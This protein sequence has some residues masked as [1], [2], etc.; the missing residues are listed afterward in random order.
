M[1]IS[2]SLSGNSLYIKRNYV[3][4]FFPPLYSLLYEVF[5]KKTVQ[6]YYEKCTTLL[7]SLSL[8][9]GWTN[10]SD[11]RTKYILDNNLFSYTSIY[12]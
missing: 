12:P 3:K 9:P 2:K 1:N 8:K 10:V 5:I 4:K 7:S 11:P 6:V